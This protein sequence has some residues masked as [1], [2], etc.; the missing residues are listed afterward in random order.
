M[1][2]MAEILDEEWVAPG[3]Y[4][5]IH[6]A[7]GISRSTAAAFAILCKAMG[8]GREREALLEIRRIR[9]IAYPNRL[10]V[11][12]ADILLERDGAMLAAVEAIDGKPSDALREALGFR[13]A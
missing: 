6:C 9:N 1:A 12:Y 4:L 2:D 13:A 11:A 8:P 5:L 7:A 10:M 3:E